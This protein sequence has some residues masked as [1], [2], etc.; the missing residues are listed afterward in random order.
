MKIISKYL[1]VIVALFPSLAS[2]SF[3]TLSFSCASNL[4]VTQDN[5]YQASCDGDFSFDSG[6]LVDDTSIRLIALGALNINSGVSLIAPL[7]EL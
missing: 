1:C 3:Q 2:A 4:V 7:I 5:G 6:T